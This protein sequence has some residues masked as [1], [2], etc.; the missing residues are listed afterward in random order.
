[1][2]EG[3]RTLGDIMNPNL[4]TAMEDDTVATVADLMWRGDGK[5]DYSQ[6]PLKN[7]QGATKY[8]ATWKSIAVGFIYKKDEEA[9]FEE[10][11][12]IF[13]K[14]SPVEEATEAIANSGYV[15]VMDGEELVGIVTYTDL[16]MSK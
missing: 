13:Q 15:L 10:E 5:A 2:N 4:V 8:V 9:V 1:M 7:S 6:I 14:D 3:N 16:L 12:H 11:A